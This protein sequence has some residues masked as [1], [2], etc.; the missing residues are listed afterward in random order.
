[1]G[2]EGAKPPPQNLPLFFEGEGDR[3]GEVDWRW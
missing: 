1:M 3:G 2:V